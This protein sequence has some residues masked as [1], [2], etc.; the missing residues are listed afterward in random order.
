MIEIVYPLALY[1]GLPLVAAVSYWR[2]RFYKEPVY[3]YSSLEPLKQLAKDNRL[4]TLVPYLLR[5]LALLSLVVAIARLRKPD[6]RTLIRVKGIDIMMVLDASGSMSWFDDKKTQEPRLS[7]AKRE[8]LHFIK[9]RTNDPIGLV[10]F[11][12][13]AVTRSP[14]TL[15]KHMLE[16]VLKDVTVQSIP[17]DG[18]ALSKGIIV[19][20]NRLKKSQAASRIMILLTDGKPSQGDIDP[21]QAI[22]LAKKLGIKIYA[23]GIGSEQGGWA[24]TAFGNY[25]RIPGQQYDAQ[26][27]KTIAEQTGG[28]FFEARSADDMHAI[29]TTIDQLERTEHQKPVYAHY[30]EFFGYF[31]ALALILFAIE[32]FLTTL[33]WVRL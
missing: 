32:L 15:D 14:L 28:E 30:L 9:Q 31:L 29:Y 18:T 22:D 21:Q 11:S 23:I 6:E 3:R 7:I 20:A 1:L 8:A 33:L 12:G 26:L 17:V 13:V 5:L 2:W 27:L 16:Q 19:A 4:H 24:P 25:V 10:I